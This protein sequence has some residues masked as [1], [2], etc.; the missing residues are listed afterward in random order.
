MW[1][2]YVTKDLIK[3]APKHVPLHCFCA[4]HLHRIVAVAPDRLSGGLA[5]YVYT[6]HC[7]GHYPFLEPDVPELIPWDLANWVHW[8]IRMA[9]PT[10]FHWA[11]AEDKAFDAHLAQVKQDW[12]NREAPASK[13]K[14]T[15]CKN[16]ASKGGSAAKAKK[17]RLAT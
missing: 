11:L 13:G 15:K 6:P 9:E 7:E 4:F 16:A 17:P 2:D 1:L 5:P 12:A 3:E 14:G 8:D 10:E